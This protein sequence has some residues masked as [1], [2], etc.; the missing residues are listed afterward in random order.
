MSEL[1]P[2]RYP[3][4]T[5]F[6]EA[7]HAVVAH[8]LRLPVEAIR[9]DKDDESGGTDTPL[10]VYDALSS[11]DKATFIFAGTEAQTIF[12]APSKHMS[13]GGDYGQFIELTKDLSAD[14]REALRRK[15]IKRARHLLLRHKAAVEA[16]AERLMEHG[17]IDGFEFKCLMG[18]I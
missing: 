8:Y 18:S 5:A 13:G 11:I 4:G 1:M 7:G 6:H 17:Q 10:P 16:I 15:A 9:I 3:R 12:D 14:C 2:K